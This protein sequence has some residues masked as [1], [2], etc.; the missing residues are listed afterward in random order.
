MPE[1]PEVE[2][3]RRGLAPHI[4][5]Q[6]VTTLTIRQPKLRWPIAAQ[7]LQTLIGKPLR[8]LQRRGK[9]LLFSFPSGTLLI[10]LGMSG[11][12][13]LV[14]CT[15]P[16]HRHDHLDIG[17]SN[18]LLLRLTDPRRFGAVLWS[19]GDTL[20]PLLQPLGPEP[21]SDAFTH[22]TLQQA[23]A[24]KRRAIKLAIM[25]NRI[26]VGVGN[27]YA[28]EALFQ[29]RIAP[30]QA[31]GNLSSA[32][33]SALSTAIKATLTRAIEAGGTTLKDFVGGDGKPGYFQQ[34]LMVYGRE[35]EP[36]G[37]CA[38]TI[39]KIVLGQRASYFCPKCQ[40]KSL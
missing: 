18:H 29:A 38:S 6:T 40:A 2:T 14:P 34:Q 37:H 23:V 30:Q 12:L 8:E 15:Q 39:K 22:H 1:L 21:L 25:D 20:H 26:V 17:W 10:H 28:N 4:V 5:G 19:E 33:I 13:K 35:G 11:S 36:C 31:A 3:T 27:I 32:Q 9:Y 7:P 24:N 16:P